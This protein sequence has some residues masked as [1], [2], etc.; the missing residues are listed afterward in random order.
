MW[1]DRYRYQLLAQPQSRPLCVQVP[2]YVPT[3]PQCYQ[4]YDFFPYLTSPDN[5][6]GRAGIH[7]ID[8]GTYM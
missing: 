7:V 2:T 5:G 6:M 1:Y 8:R 3:Q 4:P